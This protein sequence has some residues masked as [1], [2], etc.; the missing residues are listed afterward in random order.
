MRIVAARARGDHRADRICGFCGPLPEAAKPRRGGRRRPCGCAG[1]MSGHRMPKD[2][3]AGLDPKETHRTR[4]AADRGRRVVGVHGRRV[5]H[6][7]R[8]DPGAGVLRMLSPR[9]RAAGSADAALHRHF[10]GDHHPDLAVLVSRPLQA[11]RGR[12]G[13]PQAMVAADRAGRPRRQRHR[14]LR[15]GA[16]VQDRLRDGGVVGRRPAAAGARRLETRRRSADRPPDARLWLLRRTAVDPDGRRRRAVR[17]P[18]DDVLR[19]AD[20]SGGRDLV[21]ARRADL[22]PRRARLCLCRLAGGGA[23]S[24]CRRAA[25]AVCDRLCLADRRAAGDADHADHRAARREASRMRCRSAR[26]RWRSA[27]Y[28]FIVGGRFAISLL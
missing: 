11:G 21:G 10:A 7:R 19:P 27:T 16:A 9:R 26:W 2:M 6:R 24:R 15:A 12:H 8:R 4:P 5:R 17:Q 14:A 28:L 18:A 25:D 20:P 22:D 23:L 1:R 13:H 3:M